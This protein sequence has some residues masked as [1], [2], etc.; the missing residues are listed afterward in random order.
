MGD[1]GY[2]PVSEDKNKLELK[3][4]IE[5]ELKKP[6]IKVNLIDVEKDNQEIKKDKNQEIV[7]EIIPLEKKA[8]ALLSQQQQNEE[9]RLLQ[10]QQQKEKARLLQ[11]QQQKEEED[12]KR[13]EEE[14]L[15]LQKQKEKEKEKVKKVT[16]SE[17]NVY[18]DKK[19]ELRRMK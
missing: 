2:I 13:K 14:A 7:Q 11:E 4:Q 5:E 6:V 16:F 18:I 10:E 12:R 19:Q 17:D 8:E 15:R 9:A 3:K 1:L